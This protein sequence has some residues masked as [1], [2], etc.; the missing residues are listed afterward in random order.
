M[1]AAGCECYSKK[2][3]EFYY[4]R[5]Y[6]TA[7]DIV[8]N[9]FLNFQPNMNI[10]DKKGKNHCISKCTYEDHENHLL[11]FSYI[12][13]FLQEPCHCKKWRAPAKTTPPSA[14]S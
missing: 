9:N 6:T 3:N 12:S 2:K 8:S 14:S 7:C 11:Y 4:F 1:M 10:S 5:H 13:P